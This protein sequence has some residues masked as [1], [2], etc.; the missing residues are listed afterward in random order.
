MVK[1]KPKIVVEAAASGQFRVCIL[2]GNS[3]TRHRV[4]LDDQYYQHLAD[5]KIEP[6][7][8][9]PRSFEFSLEREPKES[10][11]AEFDLRIISRYFPEYEREIKM[12]CGS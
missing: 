1:T 12:A 2:E 7:E 11:L 5:G 6:Q 3:E 4:T 9:V 8:V 10:I